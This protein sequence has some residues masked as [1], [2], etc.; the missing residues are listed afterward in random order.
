MKKTPGG[1]IILHMY[2]KNDDH[3]MYSS[4]DSVLDAVFGLTIKFWGYRRVS[5]T[6][7]TTQAWGGV[8]WSSF[9]TR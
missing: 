1:I 7:P 5:H 6:P 4:W 3:M 8:Q 2:T 9:R